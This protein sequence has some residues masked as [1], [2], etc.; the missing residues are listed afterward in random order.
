MESV[1]C[2]VKT[3]RKAAPLL[4]NQSATSIQKKKWGG[5]RP[6]DRIRKMTQVRHSGDFPMLCSSARRTQT[7]RRRLVPTYKLSHQ[8]RSQLSIHIHLGDTPMGVPSAPS[9]QIGTFLGTSSRP[10]AGQNG[11]RRRH[12]PRSSAP[13][14]GPLGAARAHCG[15]RWGPPR[16][17]GERYSTG[18]PAARPHRKETTAFLT[19][20]SSPQTSVSQAT[21]ICLHSE[22]NNLKRRGKCRF[23]IPLAISS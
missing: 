20:L 13:R 10:S 15:S 4:P 3:K 8:L 23:K 5:H 19:P 9:S 6:D 7:D 11:S 17:S 1:G 21:K 18:S 12:N 14:A 22:K 2:G 16:K